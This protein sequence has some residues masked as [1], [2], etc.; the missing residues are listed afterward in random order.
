MVVFQDLVGLLRVTLR[1]VLSVEGNNLLLN[2]VE[3]LLLLPLSHLKSSVHHLKENFTVEL[4][5]DLRGLE[6]QLLSRNEVNLAKT[7]QP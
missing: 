1:E 2:R 3:D 7:I 6:D 5:H 4:V